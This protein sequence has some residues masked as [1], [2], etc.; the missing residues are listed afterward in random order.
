MYEAKT[1][2]LS[3]PA[4]IPQNDKSLTHHDGDISQGICMVEPFGEGNLYQYSPGSSHIKKLP[5]SMKKIVDDFPSYVSADHS[6]MYTG[7]KTTR[8]LAINPLSGS[9]LAS[10]GDAP[11]DFSDADLDEEKSN[12]IR[13]YLGRTRKIH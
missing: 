4:A 5:F 1:N 9:I 2:E 6:T 3:I 13:V 10:Y 8:L 12:P 7:D 11:Y